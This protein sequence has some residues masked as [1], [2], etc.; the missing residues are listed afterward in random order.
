MSPVNANKTTKIAKH[1][2]LGTNAVISKNF[3]NS[4]DVHARSKYRPP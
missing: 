2:V 4:A 3:A 1:I